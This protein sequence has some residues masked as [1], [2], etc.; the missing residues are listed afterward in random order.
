MTAR[1]E[2]PVWLVVPA[3]GTA[4]PCLGLACV[5]REAWQREWPERRRAVASVIAGQL[6]P[7]AANSWPRAAGRKRMPPKHSNGSS[8]AWGRRT[9]AGTPSN[10]CRQ[11]QIGGRPCCGIRARGQHIEMQVD[12]TSLDFRALPAANPQQKRDL[13]AR[14]RRYGSCRPSGVPVLSR[15][16]QKGSPANDERDPIHPGAL[17]LLSR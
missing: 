15:S 16:G 9:Q 17:R 4:W 13:P 8:E 5:V 14:H 3:G 1:E 11:S 2:R 12:I 6:P 10:F 7:E